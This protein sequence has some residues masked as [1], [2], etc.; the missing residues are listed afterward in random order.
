MFGY[1]I[2]DADGHVL[3]P[4]DELRRHLEPP[5]NM[6]GRVTRVASTG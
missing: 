1:D 3:E 6:P 2:V 5:H 4:E